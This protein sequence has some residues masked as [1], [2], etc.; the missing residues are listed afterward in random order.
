MRARAPMTTKPCISNETM[1]KL[2]L[3]CGGIGVVN[4]VL[5]GEELNSVVTPVRRRRISVVTS[6]VRTYS[7]ATVNVA[8]VFCKTG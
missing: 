3:V 1:K 4:I 5:I 6:L 7:I 8:I 2:G